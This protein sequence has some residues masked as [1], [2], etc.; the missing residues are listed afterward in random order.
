MEPSS[1]RVWRLAWLGATSQPR[2][3]AGEAVAKAV[4]AALAGDL[5]HPAPG[6]GQLPGSPRPPWRALHLPPPRVGNEQSGL[7]SRKAM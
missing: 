5:I 7:K 6:F 1:L 3:D 4:N 2:G